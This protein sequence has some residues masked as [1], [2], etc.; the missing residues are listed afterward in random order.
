[1]IYK[2]YLDGDLIPE[3]TGWDKFTTDIRRDRTTKSL[4][5]SRDFQLT[6]GDKQ[7]DYFTL[8]IDSVGYCAQSEIIIYSSK[9]GGQNWIEFHKGIIYL[10]DITFDEKR[11]ECTAKV[12]DNSFYAYINNNFSVGGYIYSDKTKNGETLLTPPS[13][14]YVQFS[15]V[16]TGTL[17][18]VNV[19]GGY[20]YKCYFV[21]DVFKYLIE[22]IS[23]GQVDFQSQT[24]DIGGKYHNY[25][26]T[27]GYVMR[28][29]ILDGY[30][31]VVNPAG[32]DETQFN[33]S[34]NAISLK[35]FY[36][37]M[38]KRF[39]LVYWIDNSAAKPI[40]R[41]EAEAN[42]RINQI[43]NLANVYIDELTHE[44]DNDF[45]YSNVELGGGAYEKYSPFTNF[46]DT[47][48]LI[49]F[50]DENVNVS[51][52]CNLDNTMQLK[53]NYIQDTNVIQDCLEQGWATGFT[54]D[55]DKLIFII[56]VEF[57]SG[58]SLWQAKVNNWVG[59]QPPY[60]YNEQ[61]NNYNIISRFFDSIPN[62]LT[63]YTSTGNNT[64]KAAYPV[65]SWPS[66]PFVIDPFPFAIDTPPLGYDFGN[67]YDNT[68]YKYTS[69]KDGIYNFSLIC[70][71]ILGTDFAF[72]TYLT[73]HYPSGAI[74]FQSNGNLVSFPNGTINN[75]VIVNYEAIYLPLG[76]YVT[77]AID[78][79][80]LSSLPA[81]G[82]NMYFVCTNAAGDGT[83]NQ[84]SKADSGIFKYSFKIP[85]D[86]DEL[87]LVEQNIIGMIPF[88]RY[89][90]NGTRYG[91]IKSLRYNHKDNIAD[92]VLIAS[93]KDLYGGTIPP[94]PP[95]P[96]TFGYE[97]RE[98]GSN[99]LREDG[100]FEL[101]EN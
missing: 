92:V 1:M 47:I 57:N 11:R 70:D 96:F 83:L 43:T 68:L 67:N 60:F 88:R 53:S 31:G 101:R 42:S 80:G 2:Y 32:V 82:S 48:D 4:T 72:I 14:Y 59:A 3:P 71:K 30:N 56:N 63:K 20:E 99:E 17:F 40:F 51:G 41:I 35:D 10:S 78:G 27:T 98:D 93:K 36:D 100:T 9:D 97:L 8:K 66:L 38:H 18:P 45:L 73:I 5:I 33:N 62:V 81:I 39:N 34:W 55:Y 91:W 52:Q 74:L 86:F 22:F 87:Q 16:A 85:M 77:L 90:D 15:E 44:V 75:D 28:Y 65:L 19:T 84:A 69:P 23:D 58:I 6:F 76:Y 50:K 7:Y 13:P 61:L 95:P 49:G 89:S 64:M 24:F 21:F 12:Q 37:E 94:P 25:V 26:I 46:P 54:N 29:S 79:S